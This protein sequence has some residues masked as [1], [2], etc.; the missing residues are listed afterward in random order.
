M[1]FL[2]WFLYQK[3][4]KV[5]LKWLF[6]LI[7]YFFFKISENKSRTL[8]DVVTLPYWSRIDPLLISYWFFN[9]SFIDSFIDPLLLPYWTHIDPILI[10][11]WSLIDS[12]IDPLLIHYWSCIDPVLIAYWSRIDPI[13]IPYWSLINPCLLIL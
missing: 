3:L 10:L 9:W 13:L 7:E 11:Y 8:I 2:Y 5:N 12:L 4:V 1:L 6:N